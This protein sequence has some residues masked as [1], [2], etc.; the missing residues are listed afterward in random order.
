M[1]KTSSQLLRTCAILFLLFTVNANAQDSATQARID[2]ES[3]KILLKQGKWKAAIDKFED[4]RS[5]IG[6]QPELLVSMGQAEYDAKRFRDAESDI[7]KA[8]S[9]TD[10]KFKNSPSYQQ[11]LQLAGQLNILLPQLDCIKE[12]C[13]TNPGGDFPDAACNYSENQKQKLKDA[14][15]RCNEKVLS[16]GRNPDDVDCDGKMR[17]IYQDGVDSAAHECNLCKARCRRQH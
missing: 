7:Q 16:V 14:I 3:A 6:D 1:K 11:A 4:V 17:D 9:S 15:E 10:S 13:E 2:F 12:E 5:V 8:L